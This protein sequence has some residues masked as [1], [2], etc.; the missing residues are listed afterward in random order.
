MQDH[1]KIILNVPDHSYTGF[2]IGMLHLDNN[3]MSVIAENV[4][5]EIT[6]TPDAKQLIYSKLGS[7]GELRNY[8]VQPGVE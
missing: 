6:L 1:N 4:E 8:Y 2:K 7:D 5:Y 3:Q